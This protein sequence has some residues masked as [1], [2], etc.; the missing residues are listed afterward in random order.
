[1]RDENEIRLLSE[2]LPNVA[3]Q[4]RGSLGNMHAAVEHMLPE[5]GDNEKELAVFGQSYYRLMRLANNLSAAP[6]LLQTE[7]FVTQNVELVA[8]LEGLCRQAQ[9][10]AEEAG[11]TLEFSCSLRAHITAVQKEHM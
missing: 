7:R 10:L 8:W 3:A 5:E 4:L 1:M 6:M 2:I 9:P 11:I